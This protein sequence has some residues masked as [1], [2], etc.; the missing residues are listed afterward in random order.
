MNQ[1]DKINKPEINKPLK[2]DIRFRIVLIAIILI[3]FVIVFTLI[4]KKGKDYV[5]M[6]K[7]GNPTEYKFIEAQKYKKLENEA[8]QQ[9][10]KELKQK[11]EQAASKMMDEF[12][13]NSEIPKDGDTL[14]IRNGKAHYITF[15]KE[16]L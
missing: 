13:K 9:H 4:N 12:L 11:K 3:L 1:N 8:I 14:I 7:P 10:Y 6:R 2:S 16:G 15:K 5:L